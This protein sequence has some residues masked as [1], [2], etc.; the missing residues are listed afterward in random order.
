[1]NTYKMFDDIRSNERDVVAE[2]ISEAIEIYK[3]VVGFLP[4]FV[5]LTGKDI[6][7]SKEK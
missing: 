2:D 7:Y 4:D 5:K 3:K 6:F 1:M